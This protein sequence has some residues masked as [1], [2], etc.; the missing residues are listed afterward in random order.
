MRPSW[1]I[2][3]APCIAASLFPGAVPT[4]LRINEVAREAEIQKFE[5]DTYAWC[6]YSNMCKALAKHI[7]LA[8]DK[9]YIK[10]KKPVHLVMTRSWS[11]NY[12]SIYSPNMAT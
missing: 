9:L 6:K 11:T 1:S 12:W 8:M 3:I 4:I 10:A 5:A 2:G 7:I